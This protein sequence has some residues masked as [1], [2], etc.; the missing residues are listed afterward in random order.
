[1]RSTV[2]TTSVISI[3]AHRLAPRA[4]SATTDGHLRDVHPVLT[5]DCANAANH[6]R[7]ILVREDQQATV[8]IGFQS[9]AVDGQPR[10]WRLFEV[11]PIPSKQTLVA[12]GQ[13]P[14]SPG[15]VFDT[16]W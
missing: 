4:V 15:G 11:D 12:L 5:K 16:L 14:C 3:S 13:Q 6:A 10:P 7:H 9:V 1:M 2:A 8:E